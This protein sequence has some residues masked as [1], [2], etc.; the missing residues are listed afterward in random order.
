MPPAPAFIIALPPRSSPS[1][2]PQ[3]KFDLE[4]QQCRMCWHVY[5]RR[6]QAFTGPE[7]KTRRVVPQ[8]S[9]LVPLSYPYTNRYYK[10]VMS[11]ATAIID[12]ALFAFSFVLT[13]SP[14][15]S[16]RCFYHFIVTLR[17]PRLLRLRPRARKAVASFLASADDQAAIVVLEWQEHLRQWSEHPQGVRNAVLNALVALGG[18]RCPEDPD[19]AVYFPSPVREPAPDKQQQRLALSSPNHTLHVLP[20]HAG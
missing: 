16:V 1:H 12:A 6:I 19:N 18:I 10:G 20:C 9:T 8:P 17:N 11:F 3:A 14:A 15:L 2:C 13:H 4:L 7:C 5:V